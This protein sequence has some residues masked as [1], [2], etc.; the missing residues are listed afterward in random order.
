MIAVAAAVAASHRHELTDAS[1]LLA[2]IHGPRLAVAV[3]FEAA[4]LVFLASLQQ[5]LLKTGG[6]RLRLGPMTAIVVAANAMAAALPGGTAFS[7]AWTFRQLHRRG[8][9][10]ALAAAVLVAAGALSLLGMLLLLLAGAVTATPSGP[11]AALR[12]AVLVLAALLAAAGL[13]AA[14]MTRMPWL[15]R[16]ARRALGRAGSR[17]RPVQR[18]QDALR[19]IVHQAR[20]VQAGLAGWV[21]PFALALLNWACDAAA[22][23][24]VLWALG[25]GV[26]W[27]NLLL[28]YGLT[29]ISISLRL[30]PGSL[31]IVEA[32]LTALLVAS[33]LPSGQALAA[34]LLYRV[35]SFWLLQPIGWASWLGLTLHNS[36]VP[37]HTAARHTARPDPDD[38][39]PPDT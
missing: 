9:R 21:R 38:P 10:Q 33:G 27:H 30:T 35:L 15:R 25:I 3:I 32:S 26:P 13:T 24:A 2:Q 7:L 17:W 20:S 18:F 34:T 23:A 8:V 12:T 5:W 37:A 16:T 29:Q 36:P 4:S 28:V 1:G 39:K 6:A 11:A 19:G 14:G 31:G 22:L